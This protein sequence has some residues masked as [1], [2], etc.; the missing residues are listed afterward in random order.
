[1]TEEEIISLAYDC[2]CMPEACTDKSLFLFAQAIAQIHTPAWI[3]PSERMPEPGMP[4]LADVGQKYPTRAEW[5]EK[6]SQE[7]GCDYDGDCDYN[8][9]EDTYYI[10]PGWYEWNIFEETH[11][12]V[13]A[14][15][16][17]WMPLPECVK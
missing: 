4:V 17:A 8:E 2:N 3:K 7:A 16:I 5:I 9:T 11:W 15:V 1:M 12:F 6:F 14:E 13:D 10:P